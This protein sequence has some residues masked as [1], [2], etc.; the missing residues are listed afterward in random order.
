MRECYR[1]VYFKCVQNILSNPNLNKVFL[2]RKQRAWGVRPVC[3]G[4]SPAQSWPAVTLGQHPKL[5]VR[6]CPEHRLQRQWKAASVHCASHLARNK[7]THGPAPTSCSPG[8]SPT[9]P[10]ICCLGKSFLKSARPLY[11]DFVKDYI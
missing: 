7:S 10:A 6:R 2:K 3:Q 5:S 4:P 9:R 1:T 8:T 11:C